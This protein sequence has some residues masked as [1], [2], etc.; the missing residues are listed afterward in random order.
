VRQHLLTRSIQPKQMA[1]L[2]PA[3]LY[4]ANGNHLSILPLLKGESMGL[5]DPALEFFGPMVDLMENEIEQRL[6]YAASEI[7]DYL[8]EN[9]YSRLIR[10]APWDIIKMFK[11]S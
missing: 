7:G 10:E 6:R 1:A 2:A 4:F 5:N 9:G 3:F 11:E 8:P